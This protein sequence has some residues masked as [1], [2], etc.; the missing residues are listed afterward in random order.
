LGLLPVIIL[1][2]LEVCHL[3]I[4]DRF[5]LPGKGLLILALNALFHLGVE[6][7]VAALRSHT[8]IS[9][10]EIILILLEPIH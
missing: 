6:T 8:W 4:A 3:L 2:V 5:I 1:R 10:T 9:T 7:W